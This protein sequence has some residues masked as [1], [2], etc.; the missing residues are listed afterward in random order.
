MKFEGNGDEVTSVHGALDE[1]GA[2]RLLFPHFCANLK[3]VKLNC[4]GVVY[5]LFSFIYFAISFID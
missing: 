2:E 3:I 5:A 4:I 1:A